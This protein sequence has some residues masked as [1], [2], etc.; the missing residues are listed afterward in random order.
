MPR[1]VE[2]K[3]AVLRERLASRPGAEEWRVA[4]EPGG[5]PGVA[6]GYTALVGPLRAGERVL[7]NTT[8]VSLKLGT[9]GAHFV[10]ARLDPD[11]REP[12]APAGH[13]LKLRYTPLQHA[14][15]A[16]EEGEDAEALHACEGLAGMPVIA[17]ELHSQM[18]AAAITA[19]AFGRPN[20]RIVYVMSDT[21]ALPLAFSRLAARLR[22]DGTLAGTITAG[23]AFGGDLEAVNVHSALLAARAVLRA[24]LAIVAQ[25]PGNAGTGTAFGF[26]GLAQGEHLNAAAALGG[27]PIAALRVSFADLRSRHHG[28]SHH[29][30]TVLARVAL[31]R[32]QVPLPPLPEAALETIHAQLAAAGIA[33]RHDV[34]PV[35]LDPDAVLAAL[36][37]Y[38]GDLMTMGR[39]VEQEAAFFLAAAVAGIAGARLAAG[40]VPSDT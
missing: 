32:C 37:P 34:Q 3:P 16:V 40:A 30:L 18:A 24:D 4:L 33:E 10:V 6:V 14:V 5:E 2:L 38:G 20:M 15:R 8:A 17:A 11:E 22:A 13:L 26:G 35:A 9:G 28:V 7:L 19:R 12:F 29:S 39:S 25:G 31:C 1:A 36:S 27:R 23:Q 21:A